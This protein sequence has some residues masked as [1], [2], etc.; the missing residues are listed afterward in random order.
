MGIISAD[1][2]KN[3]WTKEYPVVQLTE[4]GIAISAVSAPALA[5][6]SL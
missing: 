2:F 1:G 6:L 5:N 4:S 3:E